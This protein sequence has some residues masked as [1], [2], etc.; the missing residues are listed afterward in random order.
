MKSS[1]TCLLLVQVCQRCM[2]G[3]DDSV[4]S[5]PVFLVSI[6]MLVRGAREGSLN[7]PRH[8]PLKALG[9]DGSERHRSIIIYSADVALLVHWNHNCCFT[10]GYYAGFWLKTY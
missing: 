10:P 2:E 4:L 9:D 1:L 7:A 6:L 3:S 5:G 8:Q